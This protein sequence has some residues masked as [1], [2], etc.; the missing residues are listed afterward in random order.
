VIRRFRGKEICSGDSEERDESERV[1]GSSS[2]I[3]VLFD[4]VGGRWRSVLSLMVVVDG[5]CR[6][7]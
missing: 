2:E 5:G 4:C 3:M 1:S 6:W 7:R